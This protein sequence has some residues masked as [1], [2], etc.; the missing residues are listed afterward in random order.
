MWSRGQNRGKNIPGSWNISQK[1]VTKG[2]T[3]G[4]HSF[5]LRVAAGW[6]SLPVEMKT[7]V[8]LRDY[9]LRLERERGKKQHRKSEEVQTSRNQQSWE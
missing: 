8:S 4:H 1:R 2:C 9:V 7:V 3:E 6:K 5:G